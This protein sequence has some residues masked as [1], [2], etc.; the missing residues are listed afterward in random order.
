MIQKKI[1]IF[2]SCAII[3]MVSWLSIKL[4]KNYYQSFTLR[5][6]IVNIPKNIR[7]TTENNTIKINFKADGFKIVNLSKNVKSANFLFD[8]ANL[9]YPKNIL[10]GILKIPSELIVSQY[11]KA[12]LNEVEIIQFSPDTLIFQTFEIRQKTVPIKTIFKTSENTMTFETECIKLPDSVIISGNK[13][14][15]DTIS[16]IYTEAVDIRLFAQQEIQNAKLIS[17]N[18]SIKFSHSTVD[19]RLGNPNKINIK[20]NIKLLPQ[21][22]KEIIY[23]PV[24]SFAVLEYETELSKLSNHVQDSFKVEMNLIE[25][26]ENIA[27]LKL[28]KHPQGISNI[29]ISPSTTSFVKNKKQ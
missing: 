25:K 19:I 14:S 16:V 28:T 11:N 23:T 13:N 1:I 21:S 7:L 10:D 17:P 8:F 3:S 18:K 4:S 29:L 9:N 12:Y 22:E 15:I 5:Y 26:H 24:Q 6:E 2:S 27:P 20:L